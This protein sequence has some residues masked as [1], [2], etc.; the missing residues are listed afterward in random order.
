MHADKRIADAA[1]KLGYSAP[2]L[3]GGGH[4]CVTHRETGAVVVFPA[5]ASDHRSVQN[6]ISQLERSCG[7]KLPKPRGF[8]KAR[9]VKSGPNYHAQP[10]TES[11]QRAS[12]TFDDIMVSVDEV[13]AQLSEL[14]ETMPDGDPSPMVVALR[15]EV[16]TLVHRR[17]VLGRAAGHLFRSIP[18]ID[19]PGLEAVMS[20]VP[21]DGDA[22]TSALR[23][24]FNG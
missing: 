11:E 6:A 19:V 18:P 2:V 13:D 22:D 1:E 23:E 8:G 10:K 21:A 15:S 24:R 4:Y 16:R 20:Q 5:T 17:E 3:R 9:H 14:V 12:R 7:R